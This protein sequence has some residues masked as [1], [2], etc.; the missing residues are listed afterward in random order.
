LGRRRKLPIKTYY[1]MSES[2]GPDSDPY[3]HLLEGQ[4]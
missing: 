3:A 4:P 1:P 2:V